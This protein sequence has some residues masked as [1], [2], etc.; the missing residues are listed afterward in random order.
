SGLTTGGL[1]W[2][3]VR[4]WD[5]THDA[6]KAQGWCPAILDYNGDGKIGAYS[7]TNEPPDPALDRAISGANGYGVGFN[8][9]DG[10]VWIV[11]GVNGGM[12][13]AVP[14]KIIRMVAGSNPPST[15]RTEVYEPPFN[16]PKAPGVEGFVTQAVEVDSK[17]IAWVSLG[18]SAHLASFDR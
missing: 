5:E 1:N 12:K 11:G 8:P 2:F 13:S 18:G 4:V 6:E 15:C 17:G 3:K 7:R 9:L 14:G 10:S 16:N